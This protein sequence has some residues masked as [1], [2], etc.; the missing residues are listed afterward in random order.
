MQA[1]GTLRNFLRNFS[2]THFS[3]AITQMHEFESN[4][5]PEGTGWFFWNFKTEASPR[6]DYLLGNET[7]NGK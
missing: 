1:W 5:Q 2:N 6:W 7:L 3:L 4:K